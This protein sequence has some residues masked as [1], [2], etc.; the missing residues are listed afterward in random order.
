MNEV[1]PKNVVENREKPLD[2]KVALI[3][4][5]SRDIGAEIA[6]ALAIEGVNIIGNYRKK[7]KRATDTQAILSSLGVKSEMVQAD[8]TSKNDRDKLGQVLQDSF[9][10]TLDFLVLNASGETTDIN[11]TA[12][13]ALID[14]FLPLMPRGSTIVHMQSVPGHFAPQLDDLHNTPE[15]YRPIAKAKY[16]GEQSIRSRMK[17]FGKKGINF[18]VICP[19]EVSDTSNMRVFARYDPDISKKHAEISNLLGLPATVTKEQVGK[20]IAELLKR[21]DLPMGHIELFGNTVD[22]RNILSAWYGQEAIFVDTFEKKDDTTG[23]GRFI[24]TKEHTKGHFNSEVGVSVLPGHLLVEAAAQTL[25][26]SALGDQVGKGF[27]PLFRSVGSISF[28]KPSLPGDVLQIQAVTAETTK[29]G[30]VGNVKIVNQKQEI[31]AVING[32]EAILLKPEVAKRLLEQ[33]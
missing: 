7:Q 33:K 22:A 9:G 17:E 21:K 31:V 18:V 3:T 16:A 27:I 5:S 11:V 23:I 30:F 28:A 14:Q 20:R 26:L 4:G 13:N 24:V 2:G 12:A 32:L 1:T 29:R 15:F 6:G 19:P 8:I 10:G 25:G